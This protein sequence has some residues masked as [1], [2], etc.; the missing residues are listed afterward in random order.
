MPKVSKNPKKFVVSCRVTPREMQALQV[1]AEETGLSITM[2]LRK[3]LD[4]LEQRTQVR[5]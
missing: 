3:S 1:K 2:L 5:A 4:L